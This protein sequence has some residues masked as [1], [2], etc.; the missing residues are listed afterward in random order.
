MT[1]VVLASKIYSG[2]QL[3]IVEEHLKTLLKGLRVQIENIEPTTNNRVKLDLF[4]EDEKAALSYIEKEIGLCPKHIENVKK[5]STLKGYL[6]DLGESRDEITADIGVFSP[7]IL[8]AVVPLQ[9]LQAQLADGRKIALLKMVDL[10]GFL[11]NMPITIKTTNLSENHIEAEIAETQLATY[12]RW[13]KS[14]LD[15]L[16]IV[17]ASQQEIRRAL[18]NAKC[19]SDILTVEPIG[20]FE[21]AVVCKLG[22]DAVGLIPKIGKHLQAAKLEAFK[23]KTLLELFGTIHFIK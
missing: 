11:E 22:T 8:Y 7:K 6:T 3:T 1:T 5:F 21:H 14:L 10:Y 18:K 17:G 19:Q 20:L 4:G 23:P 9:R 2:N 15:R 12:K 13:A 16:I